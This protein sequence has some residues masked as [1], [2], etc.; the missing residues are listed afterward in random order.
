ML[1]RY[2]PMKKA[3]NTWHF[4]WLSVLFA[5]VF[6]AFANT[7]QSYI[8]YG[9]FSLTLLIIGSLDALFVSAIVVAIVFYMNRHTLELKKINE[10][11][12]QEI[13]DRKRAE[14]SL[15]EN[16]QRLK[17]ALLNTNITVFDQDRDLRYTWM[18]QPQRG[19]TTDEVIG[20]TDN[21]LFPRE[22]AESISNI[23]RLVL[24]NNSGVREEVSVVV[25]NKIL[26]YDLIIEPVRSATGEVIGITGA[27]QDITERRRI[28]RAV[29][30]AAREWRAAMDASQDVIYLLDLNRHVLRANKLFY[31][32]TGRVPETAIGCHIED[33]IHPG[34]EPKPCPVCQAQIEKRDLVTVME[35]DD[36]A[37]FLGW[38]VEVTIK[39]VRDSQGQPVSIL[40]TLHDLS[41]NRKAEEDKAKLEAQLHQSQKLEAV[42]QL[43]GGIAHDFN[44]MLTAIIGYATLLSMDVEP[45]SPLKPSVERILATAEKS[46]DL[47]R[48]LLAFSRKQIISPRQINLNHLI[49]GLKIF[50]H[51][52]IGEDIDFEANLANS[53][54]IVT[55]DS[56]QMEQVLM[57]LCANARDAMP[58]GGLLS[59]STDVVRLDDS[60]LNAYGLEKAGLYALITVTD[61][62]IGMDVNTRE[63][64]FEPFFTTKEV[65]KGT[66][67]GLSIVYGIIKQ[68]NGEISVYSELG[69]GTTFKIYLPI[70]GSSVKD[71]KTVGTTAPQGGTETILITEDSESV[72]TLTREV[73]EKFGYRVIEAVDGEDGIKKF[74]ENKDSV[75]LVILDV[76]MPK[77]SGK[78]A[79]QEMKKLNPGVKILYTSGYTANI[80]QQKDILADEGD[81]ITKPVTPYELLTKIR[82]MLDGDKAGHRSGN[83]TSKQIP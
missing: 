68:H 25:N 27:L 80:L 70:T 56:G 21:E 26:L 66:G 18:F 82:A 71:I 5:E 77:K 3:F 69:Q 72:R 13:S 54:I 31:M 42:G 36:A 41:R 43:A 12:Q 75:R 16:E 23:K 61:N 46:A 49:N 35:K 8:W 38:P 1:E 73:L 50:L 65:G 37:N 64:I 74:K 57:N 17:I 6:T 58:N 24:A 22:S 9:S 39:T 32:V 79:G 30:Q 28:E 55:A 62:G 83:A 2:T 81:F 47:T 78:Q 51:R 19:Y 33:I 29:E 7:I 53:D 60:S 4:V 34:G 59:I 63:K 67:L 45:D 44:N 11:L 48:Q 20:K 15:W 40:V 14:K 76:V 10:Q 52:V